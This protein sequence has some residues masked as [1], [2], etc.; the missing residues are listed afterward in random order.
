MKVKDTDRFIRIH[1]QGA[2]FGSAF[3]IWV[4]RKHVSSLK[5]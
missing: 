5:A 2:G 1:K 4:D 3:E